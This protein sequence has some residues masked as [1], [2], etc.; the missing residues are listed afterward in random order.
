MLLEN[1]KLWQFAK[2]RWLSRK[3]KFFYFFDG[4]PKMCKQPRKRSLIFGGTIK[5]ICNS[6]FR[7][8]ASHVHGSKI[9]GNLFQC[10]CISALS[11]LLSSLFL[12]CSSHQ[13][14]PISPLELELNKDPPNGSG[15]G[16]QSDETCS[17][18]TSIGS[19]L[20][21]LTGNPAY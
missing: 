8:N 16:Q 15:A 5:T 1:G 11:K 19:C 6:C 2:G 4:T 17:S 3:K 13:K 12:I 7:L 21:F 14:L 9:S 20:S 18:P 10:H